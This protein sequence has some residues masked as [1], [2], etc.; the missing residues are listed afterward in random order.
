[1]A[2]SHFYTVRIRSNAGRHATLFLLLVMVLSGCILRAQP[3][4]VLQEPLAQ[5]GPKKVVVLFDGTNNDASSG[6]N[7]SRLYDLMREQTSRTDLAIFY[8]EG[9]GADRKVIGMAT[10]W[11]VGYRVKRAYEF[12][13]QNFDRRRGDKIYIFGFSRGAYSGRVLASLLYHGGLPDRPVEIDKVNPNYAWGIYE[14]FKGPK[15]REERKIE[16]RKAADQYGLPGIK[17]VNVQF[18]GLWDTVEALGLPNFRE[19]IDVPND[20][21]G[22]QLCNVERAAHAL[23]L[24]D[25]RARIFTP[26]LLTRQH[27]L[28]HCTLESNTAPWSQSRA[29]VEKRLNDTVDEVWFTGAHADVGGGYDDAPAKSLSGVSLNWMLAKL[30]DE[31]LLP[32]GTRVEQDPLGCV[33]D[34][35]EGPFWGTLYR[36]QWR[37][38]MFYVSESP[39][40][41]RKLKIH[42][43]AL[44][45]LATQATAEPSTCARLN[46]PWRLVE[47][48]PFCFRIN[49]N[50]GYDFEKSEDCALSEVPG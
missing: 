43:S 27:L 32:R 29:G 11:G 45:R 26:I 24:D 10:G 12:L 39:Y 3:Q 18:M 36:K 4:I 44:Q 15:S 38:F 41:G 47:M 40:N 31:N 8:I 42:Q 23:A 46:S 9:V 30:D 6:T 14:A 16:T 35:E 33:H 28:E 37:D 25:D 21:Y 17:S 22:D 5:D 34:P 2:L 1:M 49:A 13:A 50:G 7:I 20:R 19:N 48:F